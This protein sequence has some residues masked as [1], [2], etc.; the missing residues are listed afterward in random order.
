[1]RHAGHTRYLL[2]LAAA[3]LVLWALVSSCNSNAGGVSVDQRKKLAGE[4]RDSKLYRAAIEEYQ[5]ILNRD[6][7]DA[8]Q[9][10]TINYLIGRVF[11]EDVK[12]YQNAAAYFVR[13]RE[14]DPQGSYSD[15]LARNLIACLE[16]MGQ[17]ADAK[18]ELNATT[19]VTAPPREA[20]DVEVARID[21]E[22]VW[23]S[24]VERQLQSLPPEA[25][26]QFLTPEAKQQ[27]VRQYVGMELMY[28]A[29]MREGYDRD[30]SI[31]QKQ[32]QVLKS[33]VID[34]YVVDKVMP[35]IHIDTAD[36]RNYYLAN[37]ETRYKGEPY[38]SVK[39]Q[40]FMDYQGAKTQSAFGEY[41]NRLAANEKVEFLDQNIR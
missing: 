25:Q 14:F 9:R 15:E 13:A 38:D 7:L 37:R 5:S 2:C 16:K 18:R 32:D 27:F 23:R 3:L 20:G 19:S 40:V 11:F 21:G 4:L 28:R 1:M 34:K 39:A 12:D 41:I 6:D 35:E 33:L 26:R 10:G 31:R 8:A 30:E 24:E 22:P 29:A 36:V 17:M